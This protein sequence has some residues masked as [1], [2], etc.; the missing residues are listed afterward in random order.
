[1]LIVLT[2]ATTMREAQPVADT[3]NATKRINSPKSMRLLI[4][5]QE[6]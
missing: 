1:M 5:K 3:R 2:I 4:V 6:K